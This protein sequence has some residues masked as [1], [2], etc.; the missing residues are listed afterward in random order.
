MPYSKTSV[1]NPNPWWIT[2][3][4]FHFSGEGRNHLRKRLPAAIVSARKQ[5][6]LEFCSSAFSWSSSVPPSAWEFATSSTFL[7]FGKT[8]PP[9]TTIPPQMTYLPSRI[10]VRK[11]NAKIGSENKRSKFPSSFGTKNGLLEIFN[12]SQV[13]CPCFNKIIMEISCQILEAI[14]LTNIIPS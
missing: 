4:F 14:W 12:Y 3:H 7:I 8:P 11:T 9:S 10:Q 2:A 6:W 1:A 5:N 13:F